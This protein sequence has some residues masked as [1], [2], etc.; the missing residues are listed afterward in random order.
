MISGPRWQSHVQRQRAF[1]QRDAGLAV[2]ADGSQQVEH[3]MVMIIPV[4]RGDQR[5]P[6]RSVGQVK[7][8]MIGIVDDLFH[9]LPTGLGMDPPPNKSS[10]VSQRT[11]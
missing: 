5:G 8:S 11:A 10:T 3:L 2:G 1:A 4:R 9:E 6:G 7:S